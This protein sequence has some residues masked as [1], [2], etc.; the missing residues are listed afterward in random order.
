MTNKRVHRKETHFRNNKGCYNTRQMYFCT[1]RC[2]VYRLS[3]LD[4]F[5][6]HA[7]IK[8]KQVFIYMLTCFFNV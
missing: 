5:D 8:E 7:G 4:I 1:E 2:D 6:G 3:N